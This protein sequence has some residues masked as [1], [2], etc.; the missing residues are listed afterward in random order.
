M[1]VLAV[2]G[3]SG[4]H[5]T[6]V[7]AV[8]A[9][10]QKERK[11]VEVRFWCDTHF[12]PQA[13]RILAEYDPE[14]PV[15]TVL[16]GKFRRYSHL[17]KLQ[18]L[19]VPG[20]VFPNIRDTFLVVGGVVQSLVRLIV[21]RPDVVF[22]KGG[23]VCLP[24]GLAAWLLRI[25]LV[26]HDS[27]AHPGLTN[28]LLAP[29]AKRIGTGVPLQYYSYPAE[30]SVYVGIPI[31]PAYEKVTAAEQAIL[32]V[33]LGFD[34][35]RPLTVFIGGGLGA[36]QIN[37]AVAQH[38]DALLST[39]NVIL[40]AGTAQYD[41]LRSLTPQDDDRFVL[42]AFVSEGMLQIIQAADLAVSRAGAT[43]LL[44]LAATAKPTILIPGKQMTHQLK[45]AKV[46]VDADA[47]VL[48]D[49]GRFTNPD[50]KSLPAAVRKV[51]N[52]GELRQKLARNL[53]KQARPHAARDMAAMILRASGKRR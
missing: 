31:D 53:H 35:K 15:S 44:E 38:L 21:W 8:I 34:P 45:H 5:V 22:A 10:L 2:G 30:K 12:A 36:K 43:S 27:D 13:R 40:I 32:K 37:D 50:D 29:I 3:G 11:N 14:L 18:H 24:V 39:T 19:T 6:P 20:V 33:K 28:R 16:S 49:E 4:G 17:T 1:K 46:F 41:E 48:L 51:L 7:V 25:P 52:D 42:H 23:Y 9:E 26:I 47:V